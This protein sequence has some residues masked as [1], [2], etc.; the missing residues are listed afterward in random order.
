MTR[1]FQSRD[2][3]G[4]SVIDGFFTDEVVAALAAECTSFEGPWHEYNSPLELKRTCND[5]NAFDAATYRVFSWLSSPDFVSMLAGAFDLAGLTA[6]PGLHGGGWHVH[7]RGGRLNPH[8]DYSIHPKIGLQRRLNI[9]LYLNPIWKLEWG[10]QLG[11]WEQ[12]PTGRKPG[13]LARLIE[14][15]FNRAVLFETENSW[16]GLAQPVTAPPGVCRRSLA[17]YFLTP[18]T[19]DAEQRMKALFAPSKD[20]EACADV[21]RLIAR[22]ANAI[23]ACEAWKVES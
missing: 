14:P 4:H 13:R 21:A 22:R 19:P 12:S 9:I 23:T 16:H 6:D 20:Q 7:E 17:A 8:L 5:W 18:P 1:G 10:G 15:Q 3:F 2:P 11:L